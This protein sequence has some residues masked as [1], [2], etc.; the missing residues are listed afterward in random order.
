M[1]KRSKIIERYETVLDG[2]PPKILTKF[3]K[4]AKRREL[5]FEQEKLIFTS[6]TEEEMLSLCV[7]ASQMGIGVQTFTKF[8]TIKSHKTTI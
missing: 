5:Q 2:V 8:K 4:E 3:I 7:L 6:L 1:A